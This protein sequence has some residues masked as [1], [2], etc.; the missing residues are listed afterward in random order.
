MANHRSVPSDILI[1]GGGVFG[2]S[3][4]IALLQRPSYAEANITILDAA[5]EL[6][7]RFSASWDTSRMLRADYAEKEYTKLVSEAHKYWKDLSPSAWGGEGRY[8][9]A[10]LLH[11]WRDILK[12]VLKIPRILLGVGDIPSPSM[13]SKSCP[14]KTRSRRRDLFQVPAEIMAT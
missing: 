8:Y 6:P 3:T 12:K 11:M 9:D 5:S 2:L 10:S 7:N 1:I 14:T 4:A 13:T